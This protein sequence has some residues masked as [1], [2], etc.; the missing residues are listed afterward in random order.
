MERVVIKFIAIGDFHNLP[1]VHDRH[2]VTNMTD[3]GKIMGD[4]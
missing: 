1:Q 3:Y 4:K 2:P